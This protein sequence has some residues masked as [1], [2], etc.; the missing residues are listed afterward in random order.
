MALALSLVFKDDEV[1]RVRALWQGLADAGISRDML[2]LNYP[3]HV[4]LVVVEGNGQEARLRRLLA[5]IEPR[6]VS[7]Q[8]G[9]VNRFAGT[10]IVWLAC[11][12]GDELAA[13][14]QEI[15]GVLPAE[16][17]RPH[18]RHGQ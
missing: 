2:D 8:L 5:K 6:P 14:H 17:I 1:A 10:D 13:L 12:G 18:Y 16:L 9:G 7:V 15:T 11:D 4:T 3:P